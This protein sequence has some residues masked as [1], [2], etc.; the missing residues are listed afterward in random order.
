MRYPN[1]DN[2]EKRSACNMRKYRMPSLEDNTATS[3]AAHAG[4]SFPDGLTFGSS[5]VFFVDKFL[6]FN[7][8]V[9]DVGCVTVKFGI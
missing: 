9:N 1:T 4:D 3:R 5:S 2:R 8:H 6:G 7:C